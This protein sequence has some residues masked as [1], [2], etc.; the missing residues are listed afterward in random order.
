VQVVDPEGYPYNTISREGDGPGETRF[1]LSILDLGEDEIGIVQPIPGKIIRMSL[2][3]LPRGVIHLELGHSKVAITDAKFGGGYFLASGTHHDQERFRQRLFIAR[4]DLQG[5]MIKEYWG[6]SAG[7]DLL[8]VLSQ[9]RFFNPYTIDDQGYV[10][11]APDWNK[12]RIEIYDQQNHLIRVITRD[13]PARRRNEAD[14]RR[15]MVRTIGVADPKELSE[16][17]QQILVSRGLQIKI[18]DYDRV[19]LGLW[20]DE[21]AYLWVRTSQG[22]NN[23]SSGVVCTYD[24]FDPQGHFIKQVELHGSI[25]P[26]YDRIFFLGHSLQRLVVIQNTEEETYSPKVGQRI[27]CYRILK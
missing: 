13:Y 23:Q 26:L 2:D 16:E 27:T 22:D 17:D 14:R 10:Y 4:F 21:Q 20:L 24:V 12:Y 19:V 8:E 5:Q 1:P 6:Y 3:N 7:P 18:E 15:A 11:I 25:N 9:F